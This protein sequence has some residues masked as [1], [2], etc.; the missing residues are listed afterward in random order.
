MGIM[1]VFK[2]RRGPKAGALTSKISALIRRDVSEL[3]L[4]LPASLMLSKKGW[5]GV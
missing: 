3:R 1:E 2:V 5:E 4:S